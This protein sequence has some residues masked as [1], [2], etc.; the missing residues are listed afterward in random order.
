MRLRPSLFAFTV[1][2]LHF[3]FGTIYPFA[4][5]SF[6]SFQT[7]CDCE[8]PVVQIH[9][10]KLALKLLGV[11]G[12]VPETEK[13]FGNNLMKAFSK[14]GVNGSSAARYA[15]KKPLFASFHI[16]RV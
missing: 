11:D 8:P 3:M 1:F 13:R 5:Y 10:R 2:G 4:L 9:S 16:E 14:H 6:H 15:A 7:Q 12:P